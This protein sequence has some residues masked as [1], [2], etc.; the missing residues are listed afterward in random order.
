MEKELYEAVAGKGDVTLF[1]KKDAT[2]DI[3]GKVIAN[4]DE[5]FLSRTP[6]G[7]TILHLAIQN[8]HSALVEEI[9]KHFPTLL[10]SRDFNGDTPI[11]IAARLRAPA[12]ALMVHSCA[13]CYHVLEQTISSNVLHFP[14]WRTKNS[15]G[16]NAIHEAMRTSNYNVVEELLNVD[17]HL[18]I[19]TNNDEETPLHVL[20]RYA[21][22]TGK[23]LLRICFP[24]LKD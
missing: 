5:Y 19:A 2:T 22:Y 4:N 12:A 20:A 8:C 9:L 13:E 16:N 18:S 14:P 21:T 17:P 10:L 3:D 7:S 15:K 1:D 11:H 6:N 24:Y 23:S